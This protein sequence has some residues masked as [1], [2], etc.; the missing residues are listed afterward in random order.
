M[1]AEQTIRSQG[2]GNSSEAD[3]S[4]AKDRPCC[5][6]FGLLFLGTLLVSTLLLSARMYHV[7]MELARLE[8][9]D[10]SIQELALS[11][12][13]FET[14]IASLEATRQSDVLFDARSIL[15]HMTRTI[16][17]LPGFDHDPVAAD[18]IEQ[19]KRMISRALNRLDKEMAVGPEADGNFTAAKQLGVLAMALET[20][21][22]T[23]MEATRQEFSLIGTVEQLMIT[24]AGIGIFVSGVNEVWRR[25]RIVTQLRAARDALANEN[26]HLESEADQRTA[27]LVQIHQMFE[28]SLKASKFTMFIQNRDLIYS[29]MHRPRFNRS[30]ADYLGK[31]DEEVLP[32][33]IRAEIIAKK[34]KVIETGEGL[35]FT[36]NAIDK[37]GRPIISDVIYDP[38]L[39]NGRVIGLIGV[40]IDITESRRRETR[41]QALM[42]EL[43]HRS[44][45]LLAII[46]AM[47][48]QTVRSSQSLDDFEDRFAGRI[49][50]ISRSFDL[51]VREKWEGVPLRSLIIS[52]I[53]A[54]DPK[55]YDRITLSGPDIVA[56][57]KLVQT[58]GGAIHELVTNAARHGALADPRGTVRVAWDLQPDLF[59]TERF[60]VE[61]RED[62]GTTLRPRIR[63]RGFGLSMLE[64][65][66]PR[67]LSGE[68]EVATQS[69]GLV[70]SLKCPWQSEPGLAAM[71]TE[72]PRRSE[73]RQLS[74]ALP[75]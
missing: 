71:V 33:S 19:L 66:V 56:S 49:A 4:Q 43:V 42:T 59:D 24:F 23:R 74:E 52:Q 22:Q 25:Q 9:V 38:I 54:V 20:Q 46:S 32:D 3:T 16:A 35:S 31:S 29:W 28:T 48:R 72:A 11:A 50:A 45:N 5:L 41:I 40:S 44:Q 67:T 1:R 61:W 34:K 53:D 14:N 10:A 18:L 30:P 17:A 21:N 73:T 12:F 68:A 57:P 13:D 37:D 55:L 26:K 36:L 58:L 65:I 62:D 70:W 39:E 8:R 2:L 6:I 63:R 75:G 27:S 47:A 60:R 64:T 15:V 7:S 51:I 69:G